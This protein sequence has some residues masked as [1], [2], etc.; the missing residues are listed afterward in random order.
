MSPPF[1]AMKPYLEQQRLWE[2]VHTN[3]IVDIQHFLVP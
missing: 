3:F 2:K 1:P